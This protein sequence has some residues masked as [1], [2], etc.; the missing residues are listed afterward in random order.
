MCAKVTL[1]LFSDCKLMPCCLFRGPEGKLNS[2]RSKNQPS[3]LAA[4][5]RATVGLSVDLQITPGA[6]RSFIPLARGIRNSSFYTPP[7]SAS[8]VILKSRGESTHPPPSDH[9]LAVCPP[10]SPQALMWPEFH[11]EQREEKQGWRV[12][13]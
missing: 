10:R 6:A 2:P 3:K 7:A 8:D 11:P 13:A 9:R 12:K 5:S 1:V 4:G